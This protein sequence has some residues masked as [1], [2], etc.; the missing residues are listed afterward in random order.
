MLEKL[1]NL[2]KEFLENLENIQTELEAE[3]FKKDYLW[4]SWKLSEILKWLKDLSNEEKKEV[5]PTANELKNF[6]IEQI[7]KRIVFLEDKRFE[8]IEQ[9]EKIDVTT[10]FKAENIYISL[11]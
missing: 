3:N 5:W 10:E 6:I 7:D 8:K 9:E 1:Y 2:R 11:I 4:K